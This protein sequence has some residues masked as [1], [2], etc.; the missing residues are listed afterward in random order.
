V[1]HPK[2]WRYLGSIGGWL[3]I[4]A[5]DLNPCGVLKRGMLIFKQWLLQGAQ[6]VKVCAV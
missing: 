4:E 2:G 5:G 3:S 6:L 1:G